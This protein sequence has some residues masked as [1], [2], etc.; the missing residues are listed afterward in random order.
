M[1]SPH[2]QVMKRSFLNMHLSCIRTIDKD[3]CCTDAAAFE[4]GV[5][6]YC[7]GQGLAGFK[8]PRF[9]RW[10][11]SPLPTNSSGKVLKQRVREA[12]LRLQQKP[13]TAHSRL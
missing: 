8:I 11:T 9:L 10:Q 6:A 3:W 13:V 4:A 7:Q 5:R 12:L 2:V 1:Q